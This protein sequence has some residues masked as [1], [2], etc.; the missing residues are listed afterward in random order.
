MR[1]HPPPVTCMPFMVHAPLSPSTNDR[2]VRVAIC[3]SGQTRTLDQC[4]RSMRKHLFDRLHDPV[5][6]AHIDEKDETIDLLRPAALLV[7][8]PPI[9]ESLYP[10]TRRLLE[11][12]IAEY[13]GSTGTN[14]WLNIMRQWQSWF[15]ANSLKKEHERTHGWTF[16]WVVRLR[17]DSLIQNN[18]ESLDQ[19]DS[20]FLYTP[21]HNAYGGVCDQFA[22][23]NS[24]AMDAYAS[25]F[26]EVESLAE[27]IDATQKINPE[28]ILLRHLRRHGIQLRN[29]RLRLWTIRSG[30]RVRFPTYADRKPLAKCFALAE[31]LTRYAAFRS[32]NALRRRRS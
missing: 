25:L 6:F 12:E 20:A 30:N 11:W 7:G 27:D 31:N 21:R 16:D 29:T 24:A 32:L 8:D 23:G 19:L 9:N 2:P 3:V 18:I 13:R 26:T 15:L 14:N 1:E 4:F 28:T 5:V 22:I 17:P 10:L